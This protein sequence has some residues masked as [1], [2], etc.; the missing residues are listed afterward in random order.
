MKQVRKIR[1]NEKVPPDYEP[2]KDLAV[3]DIISQLNY[4]PRVNNANVETEIHCKWISQSRVRNQI[5]VY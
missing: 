1:K 4:C 2:L 5:D 3:V